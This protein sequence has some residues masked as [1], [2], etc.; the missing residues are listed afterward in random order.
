MTDDRFPSVV[1]VSTPL[2]LPQPLVVTLFSLGEPQVG[3]SARAPPITRIISPEFSLR[4]NVREF[5]GV[6]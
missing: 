2:P 3:G 6:F 1:P 5:R 4:S